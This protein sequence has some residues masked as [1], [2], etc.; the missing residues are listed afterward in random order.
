MEVEE[1]AGGLAKES[2]LL[3]IATFTTDYT[4]NPV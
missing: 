4:E 3:S 1:G 2:I